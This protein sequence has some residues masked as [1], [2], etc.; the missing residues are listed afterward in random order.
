M[1]TEIS[2]E[3]YYPK[4]Q[5]IIVEP[6][7]FLLR[8]RRERSIITIIPSSLF[9]YVADY[10]CAL[11]LCIIEIPGERYFLAR[12]TWRTGKLSW[13]ALRAPATRTYAVRGSYHYRL[14]T[15][16]TATKHSCL[17]PRPSACTPADGLETK[18]S[19]RRPVI[20]KEKS[21][22]PLAALD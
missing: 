3:Q 5:Y 19:P 6:F 8:R 15:T 16:D 1:L 20:Q 11:L 17:T 10:K 13:D 22:L 18:N 9:N 7:Y 12:E 14:C 2:T 21:S 4:T